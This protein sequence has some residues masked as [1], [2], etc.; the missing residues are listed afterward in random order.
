MIDVGLSSHG[1][2]LALLWSGDHFKDPYAVS[3]LCDDTI[4]SNDTTARLGHFVVDPHLLS[5]A[6]QRGVRACLKHP[7]APQPYIY[8]NRHTPSVTRQDRVVGATEQR[9]RTDERNRFVDPAVRRD[10]AVGAIERSSIEQNRVKPLAP[11]PKCQIQGLRVRFRVHPHRPRRQYRLVQ[12][13][14]LPR[15]TEVL[16]GSSLLRASPLSA[17]ASSGNSVP[18]V[19]FTRRLLIF[20]EPCL[21]YTSPSPR[22]RG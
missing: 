9:K 12:C 20:P 21:L 5:A 19:S 1:S 17:E 2:T 3:R 4:T 18:F 6:M 16:R 13:N 7:H 14:S 10:R 15:G 11:P 8:T 22:D